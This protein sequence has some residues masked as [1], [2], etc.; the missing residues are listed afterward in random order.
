MHDLHDMTAT[1]MLGSKRQAGPPSSLINIIIISC[2]Y[3]CRHDK[4]LSEQR[5]SPTVFKGGMIA[6]LRQATFHFN[7]LCPSFFLK[8]ARGRKMY[9]G[10]GREIGL[11]SIFQG[12]FFQDSD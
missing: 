6:T 4:G 5:S 12:Q 2:D 10:E 1:F 8:K 9:G 7:V 3:V 11:P